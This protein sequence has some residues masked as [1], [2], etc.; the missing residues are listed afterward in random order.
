MIGWPIARDGRKHHAGAAV[1]A[2][3]GTTLAVGR[4]LLVEARG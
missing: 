4:A 3:D 2:A 1:L